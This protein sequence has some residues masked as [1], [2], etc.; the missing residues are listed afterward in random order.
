MIKKFSA[1]DLI[2][3]VSQLNFFRPAIASVQKSKFFICNSLP[4]EMEKGTPISKSKTLR[5]AI[6]LIRGRSVSGAKI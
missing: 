5:Y 2:I 3:G 6:Q 4:V 1:V